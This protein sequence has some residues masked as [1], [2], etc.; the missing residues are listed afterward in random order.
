MEIEADR[1]GMLLLAATGFDPHIAVEVEEKLGK[2]IGDSGLQ[3]YLST[4]PSSKKRLHSLLQDKVLK[5]AMELYREN[6]PDKEAELFGI[7]YPFDTNAKL[8][9]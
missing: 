6:G 9:V 7:S 2:I 1:I 4:H 5:E 8:S 3:N